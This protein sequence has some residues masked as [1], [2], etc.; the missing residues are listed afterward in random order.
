[1]TEKAKA[2][3]QTSDKWK[4]CSRDETM[5]KQQNAFKVHMGS[6]CSGTVQLKAL[7]TI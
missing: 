6:K 4:H 5:N 1:M 3:E 2:E 7:S